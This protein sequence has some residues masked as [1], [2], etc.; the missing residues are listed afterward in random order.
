MWKQYEKCLNPTAKPCL[1]NSRNS[2]YSL[3]EAT[4]SGSGDATG[5]GSRKYLPETGRTVVTTA[6]SDGHKGF[7]VMV[8]EYVH[9]SNNAYEGHYIYGSLTLAID[10]SE[11]FQRLYYVG[12]QSY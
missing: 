6:T 5:S 10:K 7:G 11:T 12:K 1:I 9:E 2:V 3:V 8:G 4:G